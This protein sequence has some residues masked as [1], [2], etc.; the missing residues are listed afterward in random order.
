MKRLL[1]AV[2]LV[3]EFGQAPARADEAI[4]EAYQKCKQLFNG[5]FATTESN[6]CELEVLSHYHQFYF[7]RS[8]TPQYVNNTWPD[9]SNFRLPE[10]RTH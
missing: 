5:A 2:V 1:F 9:G 10:S 6:R 3:A 4:Q 8:L 7:S